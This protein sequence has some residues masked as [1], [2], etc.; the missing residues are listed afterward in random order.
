MTTKSKDRIRSMDMQIID[1]VF[2][3]ESRVG[4]QFWQPYIR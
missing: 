3:M 2:A 1:K 4:A